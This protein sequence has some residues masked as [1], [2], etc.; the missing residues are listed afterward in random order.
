VVKVYN[1]GDM[2]AKLESLEEWIEDREKGRRTLIGGY[3]NAKTGN[4]VGR[5]NKEEEEEKIERIL[6]DGKINGEAKKLI[7]YIREER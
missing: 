4:K 3:F 2:E 1:N 5:I 7:K 6:K